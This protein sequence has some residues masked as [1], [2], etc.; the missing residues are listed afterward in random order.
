M[1]AQEMAKDFIPPFNLVKETNRWE[2]VYKIV[3]GPKPEII[4]T[5]ES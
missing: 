4:P 5:P 2:Q 3:Y 1:N